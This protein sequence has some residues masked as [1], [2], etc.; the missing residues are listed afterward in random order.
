MATWEG[1]RF[2]VSHPSG[3][4]VREATAER[5]VVDGTKAAGAFRVGRE[6]EVRLMPKAVPAPADRFDVH[7]GSHR[8]EARLEIETGAFRLV[9][10]E[11]CDTDACPRQAALEAGLR[12]LSR[13]VLPTLKAQ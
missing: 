2:S 13:A 6:L 10:S 7:C 9:L 1:A 4:E 12:E 11:A 8:C 5:V 3:W